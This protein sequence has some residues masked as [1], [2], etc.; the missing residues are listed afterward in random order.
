MGTFAV[1]AAALIPSWTFAAQGNIVAPRSLTGQRVSVHHQGA[2]GKTSDPRST[3]SIMKAEAEASAEGAAPVETK[4]G[5]RID[6][7]L[8]AYFFFW[9]LGN[10][11]Y[12]ITNKIALV[13][14][15]G[16]AGY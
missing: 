12:N 9:Y 8:M 7:V 3:A 1:L 16:A 4:K 13:Q 2:F 6:V 11:Y 10:Y 5:T 14:A 15:G